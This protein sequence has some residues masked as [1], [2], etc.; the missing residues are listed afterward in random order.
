MSFKVWYADESEDDAPRE[1][2]RTPP[3]HETWN[4]N[5][6]ALDAENAAEVYA[7]YFHGNRDGWDCTWPVEFMVR[8]METGQ[9][10]RFSV[11]REYDPTF[12][13]REVTP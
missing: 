1:Y 2:P 12:S 9:V 10:T 8:D 3:A 5:S 4:T 6:W 7:D 13:A 11:E